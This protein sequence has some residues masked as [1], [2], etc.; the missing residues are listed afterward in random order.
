MPSYTSILYILYSAH[1]YTISY[2]IISILHIMTYDT[3]LTASQAEL[4]A[5]LVAPY[6]T[7]NTQLRLREVCSSLRTQ[8][9]HAYAA[10]GPHASHEMMASA[11]VWWNCGV[12]PAVLPTP[13]QTLVFTTYTQPDLASLHQTPAGIEFLRLAPT[14]AMPGHAALQ[15]SQVMQA[16]LR[17]ESLPAV[18]VLPCSQSSSLQERSQYTRALTQLLQHPAASRCLRTLHAG[19]FDVS[20]TAPLFRELQAQCA[21]TLTSLRLDLYSTLTPGMAA[22]LEHLQQLEHF[23]LWHAVV[24][25][26]TV[27]LLARAVQAWL[28][29][30]AAIELGYLDEDWTEGELYAPLWGALANAR[31][32]AQLHIACDAMMDEDVCGLACLLLRLPGL[33]HVHLQVPCCS[34]ASAALV[35]GSLCVCPAETEARSPLEVTLAYA[36]LLCTAWE[37]EGDLPVRAAEASWSDAA[38]RLDPDL[39]LDDMRRGQFLLAWQRPALQYLVLSGLPGGELAHCLLPA[40]L[41]SAWPNL[42]GLS[43]LEWERA[44]QPVAGAPGA[45]HLVE[46]LVALA[47]CAQWAGAALTPAPCQPGPEQRSACLHAWQAPWTLRA[48]PCGP[49]L[50]QYLRTRAVNAEKFPGLSL[51]HIWAMYCTG[52]MLAA[53]RRG[54]FMLTWAAQCKWPVPAVDS[55]ATSVQS[56]WRVM[57][58]FSVQPGAAGE[59][60]EWRELATY[61]QAQP[62][63]HHAAAQSTVLGWAAQGCTGPR[64][65]ELAGV[66]IHPLHAWQLGQLLCGVGQHL[67][68]CTLVVPFCSWFVAVAP[69]TRDRLSLQAVPS[70]DACLAHSPEA[71]ANVRLGTPY[72]PALIC[73]AVIALQGLLH[74]QQLEELQLT[75]VPQW[76]LRVLAVLL[77]DPQAW[78]GLVRIRVHYAHMLQAGTTSSMALLVQALAARPAF[79]H[80][81]M[82]M[83]L[84]HHGTLAAM[85]WLASARP[86]IKL[87][88]TWSR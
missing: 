70:F 49:F 37:P 35:L 84:P 51:P 16:M 21:E 56:L 60:L 67:R 74:A 71:A 17:W 85:S 78:P 53:P 32:L 40:A 25:A 76:L 15:L 33:A 7:L 73:A 2:D 18:L 61:V 47:S 79:R 1:T 69:L 82:T 57:H 81:E 20:G 34:A 11:T 62:P 27:P 75:C 65:Q 77:N 80:L 6:C 64:L 54:P 9:L 30:L 55:D 86:D 13:Q 63:V 43:T 10:L 38:G 23:G 72:V 42:R 83:L 36:R 3:E 12:Q 19:M 31:Q 4:V 50:C 8:C 87:A 26:E 45:L 44:A 66:S 41:A 24:P 59:M 88:I 48:S 58:R 5:G 46:A 14:A 68:S 28:P 39:A 22:S 29:R 52:L